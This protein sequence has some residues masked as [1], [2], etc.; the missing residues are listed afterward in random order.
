M[1]EGRPDPLR[2]LLITAART[3]R[4]RWFTALEPWQLSPH[5]YRAL[6]V[7]DRGPADS[8]PGDRPEVPRLG[9]VAKA[10]R[11]APRSATEVVDRLEERGLAERV[12]DAGDRRA[13]CVRLT[14]EGRRVVA[15]LDTARDADAEDYFAALDERDRA[16]LRRILDKLH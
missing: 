6:R 12:P 13:V 16:E 3:L 2:D 11:I 15:E 7:I 5:E 1:T 9:D 10:L 14:A 8:C 4:R